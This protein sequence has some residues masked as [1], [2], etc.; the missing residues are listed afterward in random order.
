VAER[1][2]DVAHDLRDSGRRERLGQGRDPVALVKVDQAL[3]L[4]RGAQ[5]IAP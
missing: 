3:A 1:V 4:A 2:A 5:D